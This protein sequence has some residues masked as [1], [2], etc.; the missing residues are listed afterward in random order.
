MSN[1]EKLAEK[2]GISIEELKSRIQKNKN[3]EQDAIES[4]SKK[5]K[6]K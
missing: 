5:K 1:L 4:S 2:L 6:N 3:A